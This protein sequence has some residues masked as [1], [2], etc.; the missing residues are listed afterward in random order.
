MLPLLDQSNESNIYH[1]YEKKDKSKVKFKE[2][3]ESFNEEFLLRALQFNGIEKM[4][5]QRVEE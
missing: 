5:L 2:E 4:I 3:D 1:S